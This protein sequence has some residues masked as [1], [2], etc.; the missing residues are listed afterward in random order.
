MKLINRTVL[1]TGGSSGIGLGLAEAFLKNDC[2]VIICGRNEEKLNGV[3]S[4][5]PEIVAWRC[6]VSDGLQRRQLAEKVL[7][8]YPEIDV[9]INNAGIQR[10]IDLKK[11]Y[12]E[13]KS[14]EDEIAIN[15]S[16]VV[17]LTALLIEHLLKKSSAAVIN[18]SSGL[19]FM[20]M[21]NTPVYSATKAAMHTYSLVL[22][23]QLKG[24]PVQ[25][26][27]VVPPMVDTDLNQAGRAANARQY[28]GIS[29]NEYIPGVLSGLEKDQAII[30]HGD[31]DKVLNEP[32]SKSENSLLNPAW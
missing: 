12:T 19:G 29:I 4:R 21:R 16:A 22:R 27:E 18:V 14:G 30:F 25:V 2:R 24:T 32:R 15:F 1:I 26:F 9:L 31:G 10:Y 13:L 5:H 3:R 11:G 17:E 6:D 20:P 8:G 23:Q 28:R 7:K